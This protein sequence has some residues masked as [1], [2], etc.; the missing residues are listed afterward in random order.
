MEDVS[1][2]RAAESIFKKRG[3]RGGGGGAGVNTSPPR[4]TTLGLNLQD[5]F[6]YGACIFSQSL[7]GVSPATLAWE[8]ENWKV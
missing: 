6:L 5:A 3:Q 4:T 1:H 8:Q 2:Q 7:R